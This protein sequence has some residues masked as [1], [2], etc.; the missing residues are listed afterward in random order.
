[1]YC[2]PKVGATS[3]QRRAL[4]VAAAPVTPLK[5]RIAF[6]RNRTLGINIRVTEQEKNRIARFAKKCKLSVSEYIRKLANGYEPRELP[7]K[8]MYDLC[9]QIEL[10]MEEYR[11][12]GDEKFKSYL[13]GILKD[14]QKVCNGTKELTETEV[15]LSRSSQSG[16]SSGDGTGSDE[17]SVI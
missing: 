10:L 15:Q 7:N 4:K 12:H 16:E 6:M 13:T 14:L 5:E 1:M 3:P 9:W 17:R 2:R 8:R 11:E